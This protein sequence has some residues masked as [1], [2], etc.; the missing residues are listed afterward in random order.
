MTDGLIAALKS[1]DDWFYQAH[2]VANHPLWIVG[3]LALADNLFA[4]KF[5]PDTGHK[6][7]GW[8]ELFWFGSEI[9]DDR[10]KYPPPQDVVAYFRERRENLLRVLDELSDTELA[11]PAPSA[12][13][14]SPIAGAPD[15]GQL[16]LF[17]AYHEGMHSGQFTVAHRGLGNSPLLHPQKVASATDST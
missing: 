6:P 8:D 10:Q 12:E 13:E 17:A 9:S 4:S 3:H 16:F 14:R 11:A 2:P 1:D 5:R 15:M 7:E